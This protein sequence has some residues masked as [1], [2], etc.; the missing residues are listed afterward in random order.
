MYDDTVFN[1]LPGQPAHEA[2]FIGGPW[3]GRVEKVG[4]NL[5]RVALPT[6]GEYRRQDRLRL[7]KPHHIFWWRAT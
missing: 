7:T 4:D 6:Q 2:E 1:R 5:R 3:D